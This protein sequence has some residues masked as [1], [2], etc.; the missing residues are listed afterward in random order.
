MVKVLRATKLKE[1]KIEILCIKKLSSVLLLYLFRFDARRPFLFIP[2]LMRILSK[3]EIK[4][5]KAIIT[6]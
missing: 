4:K 1:R 5:N 3:L 2:C 6:C